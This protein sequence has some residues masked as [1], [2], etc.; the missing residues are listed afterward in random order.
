MPT[1]MPMMIPTTAGMGME[2]TGRPALTPAMKMTASRPSRKV[3]V[4]A[5][6]KMPHCPFL[7]LT[8]AAAGQG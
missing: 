5:S 1:M 7:V 6:T 8:C 4:K 2:L 3:V